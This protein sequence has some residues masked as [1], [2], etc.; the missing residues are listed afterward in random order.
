[1]SWGVDRT[2]QLW[3]LATGERRAFAGHEA[4]VHGALLL[5]DERVLSW[6]ADRSIRV[7]DINSRYASLAFY[8]DAVP[9]VVLP[10]RSGGFLVGD[11]LGRIHALELLD[12]GP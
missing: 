10:N 4:P 1:M 7:T 9:T 5:P 3:D 8:F 12:R 11:A 6:S 2:L